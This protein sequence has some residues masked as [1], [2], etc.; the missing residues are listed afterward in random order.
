MGFSSSLRGI[1]GSL[2]GIGGPSGVNLKHNSGALDVRNANDND[3]A[4][5]RA[6]Q[7]QSAADINDVATKLDLL[8]NCP[9]IEFSFAGDSVPSA[10]TNGGKFGFCHTS[11]GTYTAGEI[12]YDNSTS[13]IKIN[14][15]RRL[16]TTT[17]VSGT[18]S[19]I[20]NGYYAK[21]G[22]S[23]V[24]KGDGTGV[25]TGVV[26]TIE[27]SYAYS[28]STILS[29]TSIP[30]GSRVV[31]VENVV[32]A[33]FNGTSPTVLAE[34]NGSTPLSIFATTDSDLKSA[35][36]YES[37]EVKDILSTN[38]GVVKLTITSSG[39]TVGAGKFLVFYVLPTN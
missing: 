8:G 28:D 13:V 15:V 17:A 11:G 25:S 16:T 19:L 7:I 4:T 36:Q 29:T 30:T 35:N 34:V 22:S 26:R 5:L 6:K 27:V 10:G 33:T 32:T 3:Y 23:W 21:E 31:R 39:S 12:I 14:D 9:N 38:A 1:V 24:L 2:F 20:A 37:M 18:I